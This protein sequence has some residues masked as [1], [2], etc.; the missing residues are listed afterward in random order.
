M[1]RVGAVT[2]ILVALMFLGACASMKAAEGIS[3]T[4]PAE[5]AGHWV[6]TVDPGRWGPATPFSV[7]ITPTGD[8]TAFWDSD[9]AWG[10]VTVQNG[11]ATFEMHPAMH[12]GT[13]RLFDDGG[14]R[15]LVLQ[16]FF[17]P[18]LAQVVLQK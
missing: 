6:G 9:T 13:V 5:L 8:L 11:R 2:L 17:Q 3:I 16:D 15:Q 4:S 18:F 7:T 1:R 14:K 10:S 12:E